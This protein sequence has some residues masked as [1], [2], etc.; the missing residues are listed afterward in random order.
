M[1]SQ[2]DNQGET[3]TDAGGAGGA[4]GSAAGESGGSVDSSLNWGSARSD[5]GDE[6]YG[7]SLDAEGL[8]GKSYD[9]FSEGRRDAGSRGESSPGGTRMTKSKTGG[10]RRSAGGYGLA[11][12]GSMG[13]TLLAG[14]VIG[15]GLM[16]LFDP[17]QGAKRRAQLRDQFTGLS[18]D[19]AGVLGKATR[20]LRNRAQG[21]IGDT[22]K[23]IGIG[24]GEGDSNTG[25]AGGNA[26]VG[27]QM[28][29]TTG[30]R[31]M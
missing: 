22:T 27:S 26:G 15:A 20:E 14:M 10:A 2:Y 8:G 6:A 5:Y 17:E 29:D 18:G 19:A 23:A 28:V 30:A 1:S 31:G 24:G 9:D 13:L 21:I 7:G 12:T 11:G 16:Y 4:T 3:N 25:N